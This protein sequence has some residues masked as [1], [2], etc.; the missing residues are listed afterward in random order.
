MSAVKASV[1]IFLLGLVSLFITITQSPVLLITKGPLAYYICMLWHIGALKI[2]GVKV[3]VVGKPVT[4]RQVI[5]TSNH[6]SYLDIPLLGSLIRGSFV[7]RGDVASWPVIGYLGSLQQTIYI[8]RNRHDTENGRQAIE[9]VLSRG[10]NL[11]IFAEGTST[12]GAAVLP[13]KSSFFTLAMDNPTGKPLLVQPV[14]ISL[15]AVDR[16]PAYIQDARDSYAW[17]GDMTFPPHIWNFAKSRGAEIMVTFHEPRDAAD[18]TDRKQLAQD[19]YND[20]T[21]AL[22]TQSLVKA[23]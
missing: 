19:C 23:A 5:Y 22:N 15:V 9:K 12:D 18:Y 3:R 8:S 16:R 20:V 1:R 17:Y 2:F 6:L 21:S 11:I 13:F 14:T 4:G 10:N 7:S